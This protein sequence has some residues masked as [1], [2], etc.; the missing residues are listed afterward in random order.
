MQGFNVQA[1][2]RFL[3]WFSLGANAGYRYRKT[4]AEPSK[5]LYV[6]L[7]HSNIPALNASVTLSATMLETVYISGKIYSIGLN[8]DLISSKLNLGLSYRYVDYRFPSAETPLRQ[9][10]AELNLGWHPVKKISVSLNVEG[11][12]E[13][14]RNYE[15][16]Y[17][18]LIKRF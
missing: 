10:M 12:F 16:V 9:S 13:K 3:K 5:N 6:Y 11:T 7:T 2:Y 4:D 14:S 15:R 17:I 8:R 1:N 18:N